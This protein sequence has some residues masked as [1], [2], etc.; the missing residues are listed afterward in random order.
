MPAGDRVAGGHALHTH[1]APVAGSNGLLV[2]NAVIDDAAA[3]GRLHV[4][5]WQRPFA[6]RF[7]NGA[8]WVAAHS[9]TA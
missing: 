3:I 5:A 1:S 7:T 8:G 4:R 2:R 9:G 6:A